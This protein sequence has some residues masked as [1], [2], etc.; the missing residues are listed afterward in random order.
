MASLTSTGSGFWDSMPLWSNNLPIANDTVTIANGHT[1]TVR[2]TNYS[3]GTLGG[4][5][6]GDSWV[7]FPDYPYSLSRKVYTTIQKYAVGLSGIRG[8]I[9]ASGVRN[10]ARSSEDRDNITSSIIRNNTTS[11]TAR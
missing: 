10:N 9:K 5:V 8:V 11:S 7:K 4:L 3:L 2:E 1:V 6:W